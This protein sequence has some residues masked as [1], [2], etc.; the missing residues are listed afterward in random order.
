[1]D[2]RMDRYVEPGCSFLLL[3]CDNIAPDPLWS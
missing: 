2:L 1:M 3:T